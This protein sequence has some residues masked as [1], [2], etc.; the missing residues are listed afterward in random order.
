MKYEELKAFCLSSSF[1]GIGSMKDLTLAATDLL[2]SPRQAEIYRMSVRDGIGVM[3][4]SEKLGIDPSTA[5]RTLK[6]A[7]EHIRNTVVYC[8]F[9]LAQA[10]CIETV[11]VDIKIQTL[12]IHESFWII[13]EFFRLSG[14]DDENGYGNKLRAAFSNILTPMQIAYSEEYFLK[15]RSSYKIADDRGLDYSTVCRTLSRARQKILQFISIN[16]RAIYTTI[17]LEE[18]CDLTTLMTGDL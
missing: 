13:R 10:P 15:Y 11:P 17:Y 1:M 16:A 18:H 14:I 7:K 5:S 9:L 4:I 6:R 3:E 8:P 12:T 2:M